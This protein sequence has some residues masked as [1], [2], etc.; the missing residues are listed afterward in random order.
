MACEKCG[1][2]EKKE[3]K[4]FEKTLCQF[5]AF[6]APL[7]ETDF[8]KYLNEKIDWKQLE[9]F[10]KYGQSFGSKQKKG[11]SE[12]AKQ[13][14]LV[15]RIALGYSLIDGQLIPNEFS[16][17]VHSMFKVYLEKDYSLN[18]MSKHYGLSVNGLKKILKNRTYLGEIKFDKQLYKGIHK[19]IVSPEIFYAVQRKLQEKS[20]KKLVN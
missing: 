16:S 12:Q 14:K 10:R 17:K 9:T 7:D 5:C 3:I 15:T 6:F 8:K 11:M 4:L 2:L 1:F 18:S 19:P 13:G 20:R